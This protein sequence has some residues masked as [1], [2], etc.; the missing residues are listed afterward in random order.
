M[1][2]PK[3]KSRAKRKM[4]RDQAR[5][6][7]ERDGRG[8]NGD[9][10][11]VKVQTAVGVV[12]LDGHGPRQKWTAEDGRAKGSNKAK[13]KKANKQTKNLRTADAVHRL[14]ITQMFFFSYCR[15]MT[16]SSVPPLFQLFNDLVK[17]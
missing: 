8:G 10:V 12:A 4:S 7:E 14:S 16:S 17:N 9:N 2:K 13:K 5:N 3:P 1:A 11:V 6:A 15:M